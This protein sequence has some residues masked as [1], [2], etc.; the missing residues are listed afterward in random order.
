MKPQ[1]YFEI[2]LYAIDVRKWTQCNRVWQYYQKFFVWFDWKILIISCHFWHFIQLA[3]FIRVPKL[4]NSFSIQVNRVSRT[5]WREVWACTISFSL[6]RSERG[7]GR[8]RTYCRW[9]KILF[10]I[11]FG[12]LQYKIYE[13]NGISEPFWWPCCS[14]IL[15]GW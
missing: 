5:Y 9:Q 12:S 8:I 6:G 13:F 1:L 3:R 7:R 4:H 10:R 11:A 15:F 2:D 14:W